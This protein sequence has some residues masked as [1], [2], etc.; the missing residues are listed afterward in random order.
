[1]LTITEAESLP[2]VSLNV[3][4]YLGHRRGLVPGE[5]GITVDQNDALTVCFE[6]FNVG[7]TLLTDFELR[8]PVSTSNSTT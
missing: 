2:A 1:M 8:D 5:S 6:I 3:T 4:T 7:D